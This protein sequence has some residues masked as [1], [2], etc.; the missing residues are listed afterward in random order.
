M[1]VS[2]ESLSEKPFQALEAL[3][4]YR[5]LTAKQLVMLGIAASETVARDHVLSKLEKGRKPFAKAHNPGRFIGFGQLPYIHYL[6]EHGANALA[7]YYRIPI[8]NI[9]Y[10]KGGVQFQRD[11]LHRIGVIDCAIRFVQWAQANNIEIDTLD[12]YFDK[13][14]SQR[15]GGQVSATRINRPNG[16]FIEPDLI[17]VVREN[18]QPLIYAIEYHRYP[19]TKRITDQLIKHAQVLKEG[20]IAQKYNLNISNYV[21]SVHDTT[22]GSVEKRVQQSPEVNILS[23]VCR[24][25][26]LGEVREHGFGGL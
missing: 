5:Y 26:D 12:C 7:E 25:F 19:D 14:G 24:F 23:Q 1:P 16:D 11:I 4:K 6:T 21:I 2:I 13:I 8:T 9:I 20:G 22:R 15:L 10:P 17:F 18:D 3:A